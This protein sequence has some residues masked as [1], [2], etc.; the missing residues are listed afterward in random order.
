MAMKILM[1]VICFF[2]IM[3]VMYGVLYFEGKRNGKVLFGVT[4]WKE[5]FDEKENNQLERLK[6]EYKRN[7]MIAN[8]I[9]IAGYILC[10]IPTRDSIYMSGFMM[11]ILVTIIIYFIPFAAAN[12]KLKDIKSKEIY[13]NIEKTDK[14]VIAV[15]IKAATYKEPFFFLKTGAAG[16]LVG[17]VPFMLECFIPQSSDMRGTNLLIIGVSSFVGAFVYILIFYFGKIR[18]EVVSSDSSV[19]MQI[20]RVKNYQWS[21]AVT[22]FIWLNAVFTFYIWFRMGD[23]NTGWL[24][25]VIVSFI[26]SVIL[27]TVMFLTELK[28]IK[29]QDKYTAEAFEGT[30]DDRYWLW[31]IIYHNKNDKRFMVNK[32]VGI[33]TTINMAKPAGKIT[34]AIIGIILI[35]STVGASIWMLLIDYTPI[36]LEIT[37]KYIISSQFS[38]E[39][40]ISLNTVT[41]VELLEELPDLSKR[42]G[43]GMESIYKGS[44]AEK[45]GE[46]KK[47]QVLVRIKTGPYIRLETGTDVY[48][49]NDEEPEE[50]L[51]IY[52]ELL[53]QYKGKH[54]Q[55][56][57][58]Y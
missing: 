46:R 51:K 49:L 35:A 32:R 19:N 23:I 27:L 10:C 3:C 6:K 21:R 58:E 45:E 54:K 12:K 15:D 40:K 26:Y 20:A 30:D 31:G 2:P 9:V 22:I 8:L 50:T 56:R 13:T 34:M 37:D 42:V 44:F 39:Y 33:G 11:L 53:L 29:V 17:I 43:T 14:C 38:E 18:T 25:V 7:L 41:N 24:E 47:C 4:L 5:T 48:Y 52:E 16:V 1:G 28:V 36:N 57:K 55:E